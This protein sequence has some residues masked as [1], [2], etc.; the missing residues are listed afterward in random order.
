MERRLREQR[1]R[2]VEKAQTL[3][4]LEDIRGEILSEQTELL[5]GVESATVLRAQVERMEEEQNALIRTIA[6]SRILPTSSRIH[7]LVEAFSLTADASPFH[8]AFFQLLRPFLSVFL[9]PTYAESQV[10]DR[11][12]SHAVDD[13]KR[14]RPRPVGPCV[15]SRTSPEDFLLF[16]PRR[17]DRHSFTDP[18]SPSVALRHFFFRPARSERRR[19][20]HLLPRHHT[21]PTL[22]SRH[23]RLSRFSP[24]QSLVARHRNRRFCPLCRSFLSL[25]A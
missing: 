6:H 13:C 21:L 15:G 23:R 22:R 3:Q 17:L 11:L 2:V 16:S 20:L 10:G 24:R 18:R 19:R 7:L 1:Q 8:L 14:E 9:C 25:S 12:V 5:Q 4:Q